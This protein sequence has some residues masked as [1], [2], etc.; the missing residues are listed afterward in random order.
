MKRM[1]EG[2]KRISTAALVCLAAAL[3]LLAASTTKADDGYR[4]WLRYDPLPA[5][6]V[7]DYRAR[8]TSVVVEGQSPTLDAVR[9]ELVGGCA[10]LLGGPVPLASKVERDGAVVVGTPS[11]SPLID[12]LNWGRQLAALGPEGF[13]IRT[14]KLGGRTGTAI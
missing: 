7:K 9:T 10:G 2:R 8:V 5:N 3:Q 13:R 1:H 11:N 14:V 4:L 6:V 12:G